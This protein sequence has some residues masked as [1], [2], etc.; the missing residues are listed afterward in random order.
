MLTKVVLY[1]TP[2]GDVKL[3]EVPFN[4]QQGEP[5][6]AD[7]LEQRFATADEALQALA[8]RGRAQNRVHVTAP[9]KKTKDGAGA[10][11]TKSIF[12][13]LDATPG[14]SAG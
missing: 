11:R 6:P 9:E 10:A 8:A 7:A 13:D 3:V 1:A 4:W 5:L 2:S 12:D 14:A